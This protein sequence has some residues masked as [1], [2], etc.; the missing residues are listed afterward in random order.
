MLARYG[1]KLPGAEPP[2]TSEQIKKCIFASFP[3]LWQQQYIRSG[4]RV[5]TTPLSD[6]IEFVSN[7][8]LFADTLNA[9]RSNDK[10]KHFH[11]KDDPGAGLFKKR[12]CESGKNKSTP[13]KKIKENPKPDAEC[14]IHGGYPWSKCFDNPKGYL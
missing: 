5:S 6:I 2:L 8:K 1:N 14:P 3:L 11:Q 10:K 12:K 9:S 4:Q 7:K 13:Y